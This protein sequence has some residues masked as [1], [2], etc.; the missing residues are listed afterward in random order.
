[1]DARSRD[2]QQAFTCPNCGA[3]NLT[4]QQFCGSCGTGLFGGTQHYEWPPMHILALDQRSKLILG[5]KLRHGS[6]VVLPAI[7]TDGKLLMLP[8]GNTKLFRDFQR[9]VRDH[10]PMFAFA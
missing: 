5:F 7:T 1:M 3:Q 2:M 6:T 8:S 9:R 4:G 10:I